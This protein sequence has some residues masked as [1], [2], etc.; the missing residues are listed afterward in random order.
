[1]RFIKPFSDDIVSSTVAVLY[2]IGAVHFF[3]EAEDKFAWVL[4]M[5][6][7]YVIGSIL[8]VYKLKQINKELSA[9]IKP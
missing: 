7:L 4:I 1:M 6:C 9:K 2:V 3:R 5:S 8:R